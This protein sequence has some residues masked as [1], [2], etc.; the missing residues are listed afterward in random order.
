MRDTS[1]VTFVTGSTHLKKEG[2]KTLKEDINLSV[3]KSS[4]KE[5]YLD[6]F[7]ALLCY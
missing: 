6:Y 3:M 1:L 5:N 2:K 4:I 7:V